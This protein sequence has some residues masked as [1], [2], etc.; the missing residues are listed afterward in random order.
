MFLGSSKDMR[1]GLDRVWLLKRG[2]GWDFGVATPPLP[3]LLGRRYDRR[4]CLGFDLNALGSSDLFDVY[5]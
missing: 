4:S 1:Q 2:S 3:F 5:K